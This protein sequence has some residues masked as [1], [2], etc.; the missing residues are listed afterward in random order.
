ME[1]LQQLFST[2]SWLLPLLI[3]LIIWD[4]TWK[5]IGL[6]NAGRNNEVIWFLS[7]ALINSLGILPIIYIIICKNRLKNN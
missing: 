3:F 5:L 7:I 1:E 2:L 6:W 4:L